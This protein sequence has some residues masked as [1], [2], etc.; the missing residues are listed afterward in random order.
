MGFYIFMGS[1]CV[2]LMTADDWGGPHW[3][4]MAGQGICWLC[5]IAGACSVIWALT[6]PQYYK[7]NTSATAKPSSQRTVS[8]SP[9]RKLGQDETHRPDH[10]AN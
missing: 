6:H 7:I 4:V 5:L 9:H 1:V 10:P 8:A 2:L 3:L